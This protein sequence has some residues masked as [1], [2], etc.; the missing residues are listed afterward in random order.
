M[1]L[2]GAVD[3]A[4]ALINWDATLIPNCSHLWYIFSYIMVILWY[5]LLSVFGK[6]KFARRWAMGLFLVSV[7]IND[8]QQLY[9]PPIGMVITYSIINESI[10]FVL[11][12]YEIH[13][14]F[15][16]DRRD[17]KKIR[18]LGITGYI[19]GNI[20][21]YIL[22]IA[23]FA[24]LGEYTS[25]YYL[26]T[27]TLPGIISATGMFLFINSFTVKERIVNEIFLFL[28]SH[29]YYI[30]ILH[31][32]IKDKL[33]AIGFDTWLYN[34]SVDLFMGNV[35]YVLGYTSVIFCI[36]LILSIMIKKISVL[37]LRRG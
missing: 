20:L 3:V 17:V 29:T 22:Q 8:I 34:K 27:L 6:N 9:V 32:M 35:I 23:L 19:G 10:F 36:C 5:P 1:I 14:Y 28:G 24:K 26:N 31:W 7:I 33:I 4:T 15:K 16:S 2:N 37:V 30:Y 13:Q 18:L 21:R 12:G 25:E 11:L